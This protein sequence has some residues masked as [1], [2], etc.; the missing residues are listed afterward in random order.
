MAF[1]SF[2]FLLFAAA[3]IA[4]YYLVPQ[5]FQWWV[6]LIASYTFYLTAGPEYLFFIILTTVT[7]YFTA[8]KM[9][10]A[11]A[12]QDAYLA[13]HKKELSRE[14]KKEYKAKVKAA[15]RIWLIGCLLLNFGMLSVCK[16]A[17]VEP[18]KALMSGT[19]LS[20]LSLG[21]PMGIS[22]YMFQSMGYVVDV[23]R[24]T[25]KAE[26][27]F[28]KLS[29][30]V[31]FFPQLV[32]GPIS[33]F[34]Q[35]APT[36]Y[37]PKAFDGK[38]VSFGLQRM[39]WGYFKK[40]VIADRIAVAIGTLKGAEY[41]GVG[42][43]LLS[44]FY[45]VQ[46]YGDFTGGIDV[47]IGLAETMG[48]SLPENFI[49]P[50]FSKNIAEYWRRWHISLGVWMKDYIFYPISV[51][52]P[53]RDLSKWGRAKLGNF[54]KRLPVYVASV[55]TWFVTG[56]WHGLNLNFVVWGML[57][58]FFVVL[59][60]ECVPLYEKFHSRFPGLKETKGYGVFEMLRMFWLMNIIRACDLF[61]DVGEYFRRVG[62]IF[63]TFNWNILWDGTMMRLGLTGLD[64]AVLGVGIVILFAVSVFQEKHGSFRTALAEKP[65]ALRYSLIFA[66]FVAVILMGSYGI[67]YDAS[68]FIYNQF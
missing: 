45:A 3:V 60:E 64:Y 12:K 32:Q 41:T 13:E 58:C 48:I 7:T 17:L 20:F 40:L 49:R 46:I 51:S 15:N 9:G 38:T 18:F 42:F 21:L 29:L 26:Q 37:A 47:T 10:D 5:K 22:F 30:F 4:A 34:T 44:L 23:Y 52:G 19:G 56:I 63:T 31:S 59:S 8:R 68:N 55:A 53:M 43:L 65:A 39:L 57:N 67:G 36:L 27:S 2:S 24:G 11:L 33:K 28:F 6:L 62:S 25:C 61:P 66:M 1:T 54:G 50:Y 16:A 14:E 35:L